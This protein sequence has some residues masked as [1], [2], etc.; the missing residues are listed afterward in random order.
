MVWDLVIESRGSPEVAQNQLGM[1]AKASTKSA[2]TQVNQ[3]QDRDQEES[4]RI[5]HEKDPKTRNGELMPRNGTRGRFP[6]RD[7]G[8]RKSPQRQDQSQD[9]GIRKKALLSEKVREGGD[10]NQK[11]E[12]KH[13][14]PEEEIRENNQDLNP[15][16][17]Q[18]NGAGENLVKLRKYRKS[19]G[20]HCQSPKT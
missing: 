4:G 2:D 18:E 9:Q 11:K 3:D 12:N 7:R 15:D 17:D 16:Q 20:G 10:R 19:K 5:N 1:K 6:G 14:N 8:R 13:I